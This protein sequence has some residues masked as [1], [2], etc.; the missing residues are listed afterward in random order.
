M[1]LDILVL[2]VWAFLLVCSVLLLSHRVKQG[3]ERIAAALEANT[4]RL[5]YW[6]GA[7]TVHL[8]S[9]A[10]SGKRVHVAAETAVDE[11]PVQRQVKHLAEQNEA[12]VTGV[13]AILSTPFS[14]GE[15]DREDYA[16]GRRHEH[17]TLKAELQ[18]TMSDAMSTN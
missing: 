6:G 12:L 8:D 3:A 16:A 7:L 9:L 2:S 1:S 4:T 5:E 17:E 10:A 14:P 18:K 15:G 11:R 13:A